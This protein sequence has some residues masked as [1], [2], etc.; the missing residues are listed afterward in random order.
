MRI[1]IV[2]HGMFPGFVAPIP[3]ELAKH[4]RRLGVDVSVAAVGDHGAHGGAT[5]NAFDFPV[6]YVQAASPWQAYGALRP[7]VA[8]ADIVHYFPGRGLEL[9]P[10][11]NQRAKYI[12]NHIS[13][14]VTG[15]AWKDGL[16]DFVKR[17]Q[18]FLADLIIATDPALAHNL[19]PVNGVPVEIL[20]VGY[21]ADLF[22]PCPP[23]VERP[24]RLLMYHGACRPQRRL[25]RLVEVVAKLPAEYRLMIIGGGS[26]ADEAYRDQLAAL[27][28]RLGCRDRVELTNMPQAEIR[29][30]IDRAWLCL[31]Y[32]PVIDCFQDQFVLKSNEYL[33]CQRPVLTTATRY[34]LGFQRTIGAE[35][36]LVVPDDV[37]A[38]AAAIVE[39]EPW[40]RAFHAP[41]SLARLATTMAAYTS[42]D[43]VERRLIPIYHRLL[44][45]A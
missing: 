35:H 20:P 17:L 14:S 45:A 15:N 16:I 11:L 36:L 5:S 41:A 12:F 37:A 2:Q 31:S 39:A 30:V 3:K 26:A 44:G 21:P 33:A 29:A 1:L 22:Y 18:P 4:L 34:N 6:H 8:A 9:L 19:R 38:M 23:F 32:V 25:E 28:T 42:A 43:V 24:E 27:A 13:V 7:L 10:L 40:V